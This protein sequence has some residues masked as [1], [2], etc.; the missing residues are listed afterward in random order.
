M[1]QVKLSAKTNKGKTRIG[2]SGAIWNVVEG[3]TE[4]LNPMPTDAVFL[5]SLDGR[6]SRW[7][8]LRDDPN[9]SVEVL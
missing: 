4:A 1:R 8:Q 5:R 7:V 6:D 2:N 9:F 3:A